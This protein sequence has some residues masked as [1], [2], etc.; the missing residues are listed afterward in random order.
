MQQYD[1]MSSPSR[2]STSG[3]ET[4]SAQ[5]KQSPARIQ[6]PLV[7][8]HVTV[9]PCPGLPYSAESLG[10]LAPSHVLKNW[11]VLQEKLSETVLSRGVLIPHPG[12]EFDM[13]E[14]HLLETLGLC[15]PRILNCGHFH[16]PDLDSD[17]DSGNDSGVSDLSQ[18]PNQVR[19]LCE[20]PHS[21]SFEDERGDNLC[22]ECDHTIRLPGKG[23]GS[24]STR[25]DIKIYAA[26]G[27]MRAGA[28]S[29]AWREMERVDVEIEPWIPEDIR[30][31]LDL[32]LDQEEDGRQRQ[33]E[34]LE[35]LRFDVEVVE[36]LRMA[37]E[38]ARKK[39]EGRVTDLMAELETASIVPPLPAIESPIEREILLDQKRRE[40]APEPT[41]RAPSLT[42]TSPAKE[43][44]LSTLLK[45]YLFLLAQDRRNIALGLLSVL[46]ILLSIRLASPQAATI[47]PLADF[48][49]ALHSI[50]GDVNYSDP[51][52]HLS[53]ISL[54]SNS[55]MDKAIQSIGSTAL[56][57]TPTAPIQAMSIASLTGSAEVAK[58]S[59]PLQ[60]DAVVEVASLHHESSD[61]P[62]ESAL[63]LQSGESVNPESAQH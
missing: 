28:W 40:V 14:E 13:L 36:R 62:P 4:P 46:V 25:W 44:P 59:A 19:A 37:A 5:Q 22:E 18:R 1:E 63:P 48:S 3:H 51:L 45:N 10:E 42:P 60:D 30:R 17:D 31:A 53:P 12:E 8:L 9:L 33:H 38:D 26:N 61:T 49:T 6:G 32:R 57:G 20:R 15:I 58:E 35:K 50:P 7:L 41:M 24:G 23:I 27:L 39:A 16:A 54:E 52:S 21:D 47:A 34:E 11:H 55:S 29:A 56:H 43:I 2:G